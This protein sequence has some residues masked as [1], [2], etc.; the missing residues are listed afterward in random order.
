CNACDVDAVTRVYQVKRRNVQLPLPVIVADATQILALAVWEPL[1]EALVERFWPGPLTLL[2][3]ALPH[4]PSMLTG[5]TGRIAV[6]ISSHPAAHV[7]SSALGGALVSSSAN[8]SGRPPVTKVNSL[9][10]ALLSA[11]DGMILDGP[12]PTGNAPSTLVELVKDMPQPTLR[13]LRPGAI[14]VPQLASA[15]YRVIAEG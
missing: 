11:V 6:R 8:I 13:V 4:V 2:L 9:D 12:E 5:G 7:L 1:F 15:G 3:T 10:F 14:T